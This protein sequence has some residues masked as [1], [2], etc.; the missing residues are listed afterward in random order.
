MPAGDTQTEAW[1]VHEVQLGPESTIRM[2]W[3]ASAAEELRGVERCF[4]IGKLELPGS[5]VLG[6]GDE[7]P[8]HINL[9]G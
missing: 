5:Q 8:G 1:F 4:S 2:T 7:I 9:R 3:P 6:G